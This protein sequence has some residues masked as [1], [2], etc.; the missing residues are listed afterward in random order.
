METRL[1][2]S[3]LRTNSPAYELFILSLSLFAILSLAVQTA[4]YLDPESRTILEYADLGICILFLLDF[5]LSLARAPDR[6]KYFFQW[7]W[8]DLASSIPTLD[9]ARWGRAARVV[10]VI[11]V[12][13]GVR[14][15]RIL[16][17]LVL[18]RR[19][20]STFL[21]ASLVAI[22]LVVVASISIL[23]FE[24]APDSNIKSAE[25][26]LWWAFATITTVGYGD[27]FPVTGEGRAVAVLLMCAGVGLFG[28]FSAFLAAWFLAS[29]G[30]ESEELRALRDEVEHLRRTREQDL[31]LATREPSM[32]SPQNPGVRE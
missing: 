29:H 2:A 6:M 1:T 21:A 31:E 4:L 14:A 7:G 22:L 9:I 23:Q 30:D 3:T 15:T 19:A 27:R 13:R 18:E 12:L 20:E 16:A 24:N 26:A 8:L 25:D 10:R 28:T 17:R 11:R 32:A 5:A